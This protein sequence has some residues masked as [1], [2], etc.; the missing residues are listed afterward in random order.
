[1]EKK[2]LLNIRNSNNKKW[3]LINRNNKTKILFTCKI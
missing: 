3:L 2:N 1:M